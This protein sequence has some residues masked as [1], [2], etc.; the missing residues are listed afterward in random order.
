MMTY[1]S[2]SSTSYKFCITL[3]TRAPNTA[4][5][6]LQEDSLKSP[7]T[8][9][10][11]SGPVPAGAIYSA[12]PT[13]VLM[14]LLY[15]F[16]VSWVASATWA[17]GPHMVCVCAFARLRVACLALLRTRT[18]GDDG[19]KGSIG[20]VAGTRHSAHISMRMYVRMYTC[21][22]AELVMYVL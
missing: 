21:I 1:R 17:W 16:S 7:F 6:L 18:D 13:T 12:A 20:L 22:Y 4:L 19:G 9:V 2:S 8:P 15:P 11:V 3:I 5:P 14:N 10:A